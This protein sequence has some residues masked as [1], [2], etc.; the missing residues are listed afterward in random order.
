MRRSFPFLLGQVLAWLVAFA[1]GGFIATVLWLV[2][3]W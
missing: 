1:V 2:T 3:H